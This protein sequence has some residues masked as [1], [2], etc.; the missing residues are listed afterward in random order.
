[1]V[2]VFLNLGYTESTQ[3]HRKVAGLHMLID[4]HYL[5][6]Q[7]DLRTQAYCDDVTAEQLSTMLLKLP[8]DAFN[9][10]EM[11]FGGVYRVDLAAL[12][13]A[14][15][16]KVRYLYIWGRVD[17]YANLS[18]EKHGIST[19]SYMNK[20]G[21]FLLLVNLNES[22]LQTFLNKCG[23]KILHLFV[24]QTSL[25]VLSLDRML[26]LDTVDLH[27][28]TELENIQGLEKLK[29]L[30]TMNITQCD[31]LTNLPG[32]EQLPQFSTLYVRDCQKL[33]VP[34]AQVDLSGPKTVDMA[35]CPNIFSVPDPEHFANLA[36]LHLA[37]CEN[38]TEIPELSGYTGLKSLRLML[39]HNVSEL[40]AV[41]TMPNLTCLEIQ[42]CKGLKTLLPQYLQCT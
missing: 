16:N 7:Y 36:A 4:N 3:K 33:T 1:M 14:D 13:Q 35:S 2:A 10:E 21:D 42:D 31:Q 39:C 11:L 12:T 24:C 19:G 28:N 30:K 41:N 15:W 17:P 32:L 23:T 18:L 37:W 27:G 26:R 38:L 25:R 20:S 5:L 8:H 6:E 29:R 34:R 22:R 9:D 40:N